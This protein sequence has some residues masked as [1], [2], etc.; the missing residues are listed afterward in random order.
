M[1]MSNDGSSVYNKKI[2]SAEHEVVKLID[3]AEF[4]QKQ[5]IEN[6]DLMKINIEGGEYD[7]LTH[8]IDIGFIE[9][10]KI[11]I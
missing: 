6:I 7:L 10:I 5:K 11:I 3:A 8:L 1:A 2:V 9:N 4:L